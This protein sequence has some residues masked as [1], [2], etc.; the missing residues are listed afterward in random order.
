LTV[1]S[2][3]S[4]CDMVILLYGIFFFSQDGF[5]LSIYIK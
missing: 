5:N 1:C 2:S 3:I 4:T